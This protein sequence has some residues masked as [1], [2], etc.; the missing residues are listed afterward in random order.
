MTLACGN[1]F[2]WPHIYINRFHVAC[3]ATAV[4]WSESRSKQSDLAILQGHHL[5]VWTQTIQ[6]A[7]WMPIYKLTLIFN[8]YVY[9]L[10]S[11]H[12]DVA[13]RALSRFRISEFTQNFWVFSLYIADFW[14]TFW[15]IWENGSNWSNLRLRISVS[16][17]ERLKNHNIPHLRPNFT[18]FTK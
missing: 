8:G 17:L 11:S 5:F 12:V 13:I 7:A 4:S 10:L 18:M 3:C 14:Q 2:S 9:C 6:Q 15:V 1:P 16:A